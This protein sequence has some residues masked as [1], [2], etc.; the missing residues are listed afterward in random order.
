MTYDWLKPGTEVVLRKSPNDEFTVIE[1]INKVHKNGNFT[2]GK[3]S[4]QY[5]PYE[6][7]YGAGGTPT[8]ETYYR[9]RHATVVTD[10][11]RA[12]INLQRTLRAAKETIKGEMIRL[13]HLVRSAIPNAEQKAAI[14]AEAEAIIARKE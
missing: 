9:M 4:Q 6:N 2:I 8:G 12:E 7:S 14:I 13:D 3:S 5:R 10:E 1:K 11:I